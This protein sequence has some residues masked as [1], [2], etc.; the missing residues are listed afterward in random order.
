MYAV[1]IPDSEMLQNGELIIPMSPVYYNKRLKFRLHEFSDEYFNSF[2]SL[3]FTYLEYGFYGDYLTFVIGN[4]YS[5]ELPLGELKYFTDVSV[6]AYMCADPCNL[7]I[8]GTRI[9]IVDPSSESYCMELIAYAQP[10][11]SC[12]VLTGQV[13]GDFSIT[14]TP[15][16]FHAVSVVVLPIAIVD[17]LYSDIEM[18]T[19]SSNFGVIHSATLY[20]PLGSRQEIV[21]NSINIG[22]STA[23]FSV[24][25][26]TNQSPVIS[27]IPTLVG[28]VGCYII[29][30][31]IVT[32]LDS[33]I[34][35]Y[36]GDFTYDKNTIIYSADAI[37][38]FIKLVSVTVN[39]M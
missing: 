39:V 23:E 5:A 14:I 38:E 2:D 8:S 22:G 24:W 19:F 27:E 34:I 13:A 35:S 11:V 32:D 18:H 36:S 17:S 37:G 6:T 31:I 4:D 12:F 9:T 1:C 30:S 33:D 10:Y 21:I 7:I 28:W 16:L 15:D 3:E 20:L 25:V 29:Y 26:N